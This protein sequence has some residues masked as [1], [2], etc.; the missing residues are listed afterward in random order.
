[1][2]NINIMDSIVE[3]IPFYSA[4]FKLGNAS[5]SCYFIENGEK[6]DHSLISLGILND[7]RF[8]IKKD[9]YDEMVMKNYR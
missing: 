9:D 3:L 2:Q 7:K 4:D 5:I 1:A 6:G 8:L